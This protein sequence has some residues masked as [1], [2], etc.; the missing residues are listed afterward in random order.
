M[1]L[2]YAG[3]DATRARMN[4]IEAFIVRRYRL[5]FVKPVPGISGPAIK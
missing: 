2:G 4:R 3:E 1:D 5:P